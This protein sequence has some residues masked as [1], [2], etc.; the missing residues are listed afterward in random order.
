MY[1][2]LSRPQNFAPLPDGPLSI[3][4]SWHPIYLPCPVQCQTLP[5]TLDHRF[6]CFPAV[7]ALLSL[8]TNARNLTYR[9]SSHLPTAAATLPQFSNSDPK[10]A[11]LECMP[12]TQT[13]YLSLLP[14]W[15]KLRD[16]KL[17]EFFARWTGRD[18]DY[19]RRLPACC[20]SA[21]VG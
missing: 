15:A 21:Y 16:Y 19:G 2:V 1:A 11:D 3:S 12:V 8:F 9:P 7:F 20:F 6:P 14:Q 13:K 5:E 4:Q 10:I 17:N 18:G